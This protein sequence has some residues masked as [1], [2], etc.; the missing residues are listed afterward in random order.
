MLHDPTSKENVPPLS[1]LSMAHKAAN[2]NDMVLMAKQIREEA[3]RAQL[4]QQERIEFLAASYKESKQRLAKASSEKLQA[5]KQLEEATLTVEAQA[6]ELAALKER[7]RR[8]VESSADWRRDSAECED[9]L[10]QMQLALADAQK[11]N[12]QLATRLAAVEAER[13]DLLRQN[14]E[15]V[16]VLSTQRNTLM[17][18]LGATKAALDEAQIQLKS[19]TEGSIS[20]EHQA[21]QLQAQLDAAC[22][23]REEVTSE[24]QKMRSQSDATLVELKHKSELCEELTRHRRGDAQTLSKAREEVQY[25][26]DIIAQLSGHNNVKQKIQ[27]VQKI[28]SDNVNLRKENLELRNEIRKYTLGLQP[29]K[30]CVEEAAAMILQPAH[31]EADARGSSRQDLSVAHWNHA[32]ATTDQVRAARTIRTSKQLTQPKTPK[33]HAAHR[34]RKGEQR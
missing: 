12:Q 14:N 13:D 19:R 5:Q 28:E 34:V 8:L 21:R 6:K 11:G 1:K 33:L 24:L 23:E 29:A 26:N 2:V 16:A 25:L 32:S 30:V 9:K 3:N 7:E 18:E 17:N 27:R 10:Q 31:K 15:R 4:E 22:S 20:L